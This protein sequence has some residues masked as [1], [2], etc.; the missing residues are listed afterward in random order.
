MNKPVEQLEWASIHRK[1]ASWRKQLI[2]EINDIFVVP[3]YVKL[4]YDTFGGRLGQTFLEVGSG[5]GDLS[6]A[7]LA[8]NRG[9]IGSYTVSDY[10]PGTVAWLRELGL[11]AI[12]A[13]AQALPCGD[14][15]YD[16]VI[17]FDVMHHVDDPRAMAREM[18]R[19]GRGKGLLVESNGLSLPRRLLELT[20]G[21]RAAGERSYT[22]GRYR[23]FFQGHAGYTLT[24]FTIYPFLFPFKC[25]PKMLPAL[26]WFNH[27]VERLPL[28]RWQC[29]SVAIV[30]EYERTTA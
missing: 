25:P 9:E 30:V 18:M 6:Q 17:D 28:I 2:G 27:K 3:R 4:F 24:R 21:H 26:A 29:S 16:A 20:P 19:V 5:N 23:S 13:D 22:P 15:E 11:N 7:V 12:Q 8:A 10:T 14:A 1:D